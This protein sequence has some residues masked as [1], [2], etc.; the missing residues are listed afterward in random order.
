[1]LAL[2]GITVPVAALLGIPAHSLLG[3]MVGP[4]QTLIL[5]MVVVTAPIFLLAAWIAGLLRSL[6]PAD[7]RLGELSLPSFTLPRPEPTSDLP[8]IILTVVV[9]SAFLFDFIVLAAMIWFSYQGR[10]R[11]RD[12]VD[13]AFEERA[14]V[15]PLS[16]PGAPTPATV[17]PVRGAAA[18]DDSTGAYLAALDA[19]AEDGRW[20]RRAHETPAAHLSRARAEGLEGPSFGRLAAAY[21]LARYSPRPLPAR[22]VKRARIRLQTLLERLRHHGQRS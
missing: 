8:G 6:L 14:I 19:L 9:A 22:E 15:V 12:F 17:A 5:L 1:A 10:R 2:T 18:A 21:Q 4:L 20:P 11:R 13:P 7:F 16:A 3:T